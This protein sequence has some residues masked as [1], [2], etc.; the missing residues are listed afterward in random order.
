[1]EMA[2]KQKEKELAMLQAQK[3]REWEL[4]K[5]RFITENQKAIFGGTEEQ[6]KKMATLITTVFPREIAEKLFAKLSATAR[7]RSAKK[8]WGKAHHDLL[9]SPSDI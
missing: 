1:M 9:I 6:R 8:T 4:S 3:D 5:I 2:D 7:S